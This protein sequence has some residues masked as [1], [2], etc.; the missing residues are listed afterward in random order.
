MQLANVR[1]SSVA[2]STGTSDDQRKTSTAKG[3]KFINTTSTSLFLLLAFICVMKSHFATSAVK[4]VSFIICFNQVFLQILIEHH[5]ESA[6]K[7]SFKHLKKSSFICRVTL[8]FQ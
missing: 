6:S 7:M 3:K 1:A 5:H 2:L 8:I 4:R